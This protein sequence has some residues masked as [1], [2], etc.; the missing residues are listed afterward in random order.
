[1]KEYKASPNNTL[2][3]FSLSSYLDSNSKDENHSIKLQDKIL[4]N[5]ITFDD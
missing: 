2:T 5:S 3:E 4:L 1:M